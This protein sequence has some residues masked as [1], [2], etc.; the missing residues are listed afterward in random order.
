MEY[1]C[2]LFKR[3]F[4]SSKA[5][6]DG[7]ETAHMN[8]MGQLHLDKRIMIK[9]FISYSHDNDTHRQRVHALAD[10][11]RNDGVDIILDRDCGSGGPDEGWDKWSESQAEKAEIVLP[12][13]TPEYR[14]CWNGEQLSGM[15]Q[16]AIHELK[17]LY[18]RLYEAGNQINFCR[19]ITFEDDHRNCIPAF[20][21]GLPSFDAQRNYDQIIDWLRDRG[22]APPVPNHTQIV[23]S[24]PSRPVDYRCPLADRVEQF[25]AFMDMVTHNIP[26][27]IF[28]IEGVSN[29]G[30]TVLSNELFKLAKA[31]DLD[32]VLLDLKG[33]PSLTELFD[34]LA[35]DIDAKILPAF[36][37]ASG[38]AR[39][40][41]LLKDLEN[42]RKPL[43]LGFD[44]Y[45]QV[46]Q[47]I[48]DWIEGQFLRRADQCPGLLVLVAGIEVPNPTRY[49]WG[50]LAISRELLPI[51]EKKYWQEYTE[52]VLGN[53]Q[54]TEDHIEALLYVSQGEPGQTSA[55][56]Q[57]FDN[58]KI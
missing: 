11:L 24:W 1:F 33:C 7:I 22:A 48:A 18:R 38:S 43:L 37:S 35:L 32:S 55:L 56:L 46:A 29:T 57:S 28:L 39:K 19:I 3:T 16:G 10:R 20:I 26:Q 27:R 23:I 44:T 4:H 54:I 45:Q 2:R 9:V 13:F 34:L 50:G 5:T 58:T 52:R 25:G 41:A 21:R 47:D 12:V 17:V 53:K 42:L 15:R 40:T 6:I 30:K 49:S 36:H 51:R 14:K 31:L 8:R